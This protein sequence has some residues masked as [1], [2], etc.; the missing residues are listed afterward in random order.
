MESRRRILCDVV[1]IL[2]LTLPVQITLYNR[3]NFSDKCGACFVSINM[4]MDVKY[5]SQRSILRQKACVTMTGLK[6]GF[7]SNDKL[8]NMLRLAKLSICYWYL[9]LLSGDIQLNPGP[10]RRVKDPC[11]ICTKGCL[12][13]AIMWD[14]CD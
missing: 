3:E 7:P 14:Y 5:Y 1:F 10:V 9:L 11:P 12:T 6:N 4:K 8:R 2:Y 13:K